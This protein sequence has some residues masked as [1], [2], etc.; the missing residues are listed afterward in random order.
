MAD[1]N[2]IRNHN[3]RHGHAAGRRTVEYRIWRGMKSR[4]QEAKNPSFPDYGG[5]GIRVCE[6]WQSF[7]NF[8]A[9]MGPRPSN[10]SLDRINNDGNYEPSNCR[11]ASSIEQARNRRPKKNNRG[12]SRLSDD[13]IRSIRSA[14]QYLGVVPLLSQAVRIDPFCN[15]QNS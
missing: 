14:Q 11:W 8:L 2:G 15:R 4:C 12:G 1:Q 7:E 3:F 5:R 9:D 6:S 10:M 13:D